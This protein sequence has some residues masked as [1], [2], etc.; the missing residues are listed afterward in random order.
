MLRKGGCAGLLQDEAWLPKPGD[1]KATLGK[2]I[3]PP[4]Q[5]KKVFW[6][7]NAAIKQMVYSSFHLTEENIPYYIESLN[8]FQPQAI[9]G[10][11]F[12]MY[13]IATYMIRHNAK[14]DFTPIAIFPTA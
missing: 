10:F 11:P 3:L 13:D 7:Y 8:R 2:H 12:S 4:N 9:D 6:R 5:K 14:L 1:E